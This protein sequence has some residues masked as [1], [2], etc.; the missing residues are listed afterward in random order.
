MVQWQ[1]RPATLPLDDELHK[2]ELE[3]RIAVA[4]RQTV[5]VLL[6]TKQMEAQS[7]ELSRPASPASTV[8]AYTTF[9]LA[10]KATDGHW[11]FGVDTAT[12]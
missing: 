9:F 12:F 10:T 11:W 7:A 4:R 2:I 3:G 5:A 6:E 1:E 8:T